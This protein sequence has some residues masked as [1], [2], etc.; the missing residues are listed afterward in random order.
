MFVS[1]VLRKFPVQVA[2]DRICTKPYIL[3]SSIEG[4]KPIQIPVGTSI[5]IPTYS[6]HHDPQFFADPEKFDPER[7][8]EESKGNMTSYAYE[9]FG[10]GPR[11]CIGQRFALIETKLVFF[12]LLSKFE[13]VPVEKTQ[14]PLI[15]KKSIMVLSSEDGFWLGL[16]RL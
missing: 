16:K 2:T 3:Q 11:M 5:T 8:S 9:P 7:F 6:L 12:Y 1:E 4:E 14:I 10:I 15:Y 13:L